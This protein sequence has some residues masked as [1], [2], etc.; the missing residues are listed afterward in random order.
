M[1]RWS[2]LVLIHT[3]APFVPRVLAR[4]I[5]RFRR[6]LELRRWRRDYV[7]VPQ[8]ADCHDGAVDREGQPS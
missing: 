7:H 8:G 4:A 6:E 3:M 2:D 5:E 1:L